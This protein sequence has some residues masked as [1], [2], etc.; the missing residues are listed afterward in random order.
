M[1][2]LVGFRVDFSKKSTKRLE[3]EIKNYTRLFGRYELKFSN[4]FKNE[5]YL[6]FIYGL[7]KKY[8]GNNFTL[9]LPKNILIDKQERKDC[10]TLLKFLNKNNYNTNLVTHIPVNNDYFEMLNIL[11][12]L[13]NNLPQGTM[14]LLENVATIENERYFYQINN[15]FQNLEI[16]NVF[17]VGF[18]LDFG[19]L[20]YGYTK[21]KKTQ[22]FALN[23]LKNRT[24]IIKNI[25]E[26]HFHD[27][28]YKTDHL[29]LGQGI[30]NINL[31]SRFIKEYS[32]ESNLIIET[33]VKNPIIDGIDQV[34]TAEHI[35]GSNYRETNL[36]NNS[37]KKH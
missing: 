26:L 21:E 12:D 35:L 25:H 27:F 1:N 5:N 2:T 31:I 33:T 37:D 18:C 30:M 23:E 9:H 19:H 17:N 29:Q 10:K 7:S 34:V 36:D 11:K 22:S 4:Y 15:L 24:Y 3:D 16:I 20:L 32:L 28:T 6:D 13:S 14:L 8:L